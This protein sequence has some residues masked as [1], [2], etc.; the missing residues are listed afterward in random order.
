[1][2]NK[3][4]RPLLESKRD[5]E[6]AVTK[7]LCQADLR[8]SELNELLAIN[9][10]DLMRDYGCDLYMAEQVINHAKYEQFRL[11]AQDQY[12]PS[13]D[14]GALWPEK[15]YTR[16]SPINESPAGTLK[17]IMTDAR[18]TRARVLGEK[19]LPP[20]CEHKINQSQAMLRSVS[21]YLE[22]R[23]NKK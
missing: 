16:T 14:T 2:R 5:L 11:R 8:P 12:T 15:P 3:N 20:W 9:Q 7:A 21:R 23:A 1:M 6:L 22:T 4:Q 10:S 17:K 13:D 18:R 19:D